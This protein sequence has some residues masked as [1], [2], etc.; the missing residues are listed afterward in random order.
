VIAAHRRRVHA[1][2]AP[3]EE[4]QFVRTWTHADHWAAVAQP[5]AKK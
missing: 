2:L 5:A 4:E 3:A 1:E